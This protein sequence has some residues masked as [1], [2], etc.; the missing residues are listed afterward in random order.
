MVIGATSR[1]ILGKIVDIQPKKVVLFLEERDTYVEA[2]RKIF[3]K[4]LMLNQQVKVNV[5]FWIEEGYTRIHSINKF[6]GFVNLFD[7][8]LS[9]NTKFIKVFCV[10]RD[11]S[12][13]AKLRS[14][15]LDF[16]SQCVIS[17]CKIEPILEA[18]HIHPVANGGE[19]SMGN[20]LLLRSDLH[21]MFDRGLITIDSESYLIKLSD[22]IK[23]FEQYADLSGKIA[24][25]PSHKGLREKLE[26]HNK[27]VFL[28]S[29]NSQN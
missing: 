20:S 7:E 28:V 10:V 29:P 22:S 13:Q 6:I 15:L 23:D 4:G 12:Q 5:I 14:D 27:N 25:L 11:P 18:A 26:W 24:F 19:C 16:Y 1:V 2:E 9:E 8:K 3:P 17:A 21:R